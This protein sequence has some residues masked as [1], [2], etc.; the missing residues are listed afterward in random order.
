M[1]ELEA[2]LVER[3]RLMAELQRLAAPLLA[4]LRRNLSACERVRLTVHFDDGSAQERTRA[5][6]FPLAEEGRAIRILGQM[7]DRL[8]WRAAASALSVALEEIQDAVARQLPLFHFE[9]EGREKLE[10]VQRYLTARFGSNRLRRAVLT[11]P[12]A[13]LPEWRVGWRV[14]DE[15]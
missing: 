15:P 8:H 5:L 11:Q 4:K 1:V 7:L 3:D 14:E 10:E 13:P 2:P 9:D 6:L 12:G